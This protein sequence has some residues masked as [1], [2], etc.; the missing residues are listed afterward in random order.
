MPNNGKWALIIVDGQKIWYNNKRDTKRAAN[1]ARKRTTMDNRQQTDLPDKTERKQYAADKKQ[2]KKL[3]KQAK[4]HHKTERKRLRKALRLDYDAVRQEQLQ[5]QLG[6]IAKLQ[7]NNKKWYRLDNAALMYP[8]VARSES[9]S[10]FRLAVVL[11]QPVDPVALQYAVNDICPRFPTICGSVKNG[12]FWPYIDRPA[13]PITVEKQT[14]VPARP[15]KMDSRRSQIRVNYYENQIAVEFFHSATDGTGGIVF[16]NSL[17]RCYFQKL[18]IDSD[19]VNCLDY[20]DV[21]SLEEIRDNFANVA[22]AKNP[23]PMPPIVKCRSINGTFLKNKKYVTVRGIC[24]ANALHALARRHNAT[25]TEFL[26]AIQLLA[27]DR[28]CKVTDTKTNKP[29]RV[30]VPV[31]LR[32]IYGVE[33]VRNFSSYIFYQY[34]G[35]TELDQVI[36][37]IHRQA[38]EQLTDDYFRGMVSYNYNSGNNPFL[39]IVPLGIKRMVVS[40]IVKGRGDGIVNNSSL[41]NAGVVQAPPQ[42]AEHVLRYEFMLGKPARRTNNFTVIT[43]GDVCVISVTNIFAETDCER[44]FFRT[45]SD[46][47][48]DL[49]I[50]SDIWENAE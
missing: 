49:A 1:S 41:S 22:I 7:K 5:L 16:L 14:K 34:N 19:L 48:L 9:I 28:L 8:L 11:K 21:P 39:K 4:K 23:P 18:G 6:K 38:Q 12:F 50:E 37:D 32:K 30:L 47:G 43:Y 17:L 29:L 27:L 36:A 26:G 24:S 33:T 2:G 44:L 25:V 42:F 13:V 20:R 35:Q 3:L 46:M 40:A 10:I 45:L 15:M 31:N